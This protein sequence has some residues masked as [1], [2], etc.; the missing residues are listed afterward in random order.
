MSC[1]DIAIL[2]YCLDNG[3]HKHADWT[4]WRE[5]QLENLPEHCSK[6]ERSKCGP[7]T[8]FYANQY[9]DPKRFPHGL[10][11]VAGYWA[12]LRI[13]GG[14]VLFDRG[15]SEDEVSFYGPTDFCAKCSAKTDLPH[16]AMECIYMA[17][18]PPP[19]H[20]PQNTNSRVY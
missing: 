1:H 11:D 13:F 12:E 9:L 6:R 4:S 5:Q 10:A 14:V 17:Q 16:N 8:L 2:L 18:S 19:S 3:V 15:Q 20:R 7:P